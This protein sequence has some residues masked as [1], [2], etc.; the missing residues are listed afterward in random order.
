MKTDRA[1]EHLNSLNREVDTFVNDNPHTFK[2]KDDLKNARYVHRIEYKAFPPILGMLLG[3]FIYSLRSGLDQLA[4]QLAL[5]KTDKPGR[6]VKFPIFYRKDRAYETSLKPFT[7]PVKDA[8]DCLQPYHAGKSF[9]DHPLWQLNRLSNLDKHQVIPIN[10]TG[11]NVF[12][13]TL[14][15]SQVTTVDFDDA[16]EFHVPLSLKD[17]M[18]RQPFTTSQIL[19]GEWGSDLQMPRSVLAE[20]HKFITDEVIPRFTGFFSSSA[21]TALPRSRVSVVKRHG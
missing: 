11:V 16:I 4:W 15:L 21:K 14:D 6:E 13:P 1:L 19:L 5:L 17:E 9:Q 12:I 7:K 18:Q 20:M 8:I 10:S 2:G 3:E